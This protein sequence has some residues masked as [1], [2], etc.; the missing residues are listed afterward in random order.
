MNLSEVRDYT[1]FD[2]ETTGLDS[3]ADRI[4]QVGL[5]QVMSDQVVNQSGWLVK[6][7]RR[8]SPDAL[9]RHGIKDAD[10]QVRGI[11]PAESLQRLLAA[12]NPA[13]HCIG[14]NVHRFDVA[15]LIA[16]CER[17]GHGAPDCSEYIDTAALY[18]GHKLRR[19]PRPRESQQQYANR[20]LSER[21][22]GL[23][24]SVETCIADLVIPHDKSQLHQAGY[25]AYLTHMIFQRL[26]AQ[27][28]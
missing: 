28:S 26:R 4:I 19:Q 5:C 13:P 17:L 18:K 24:Y 6:Q 12:L 20:I 25:D 9:Q 14:H 27:F 21:V 11:D 22:R 10:I 23:K 16:E 8:I 7:G 3:Q 2:F 1:V 15:F